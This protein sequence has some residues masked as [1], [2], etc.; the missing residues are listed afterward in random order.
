MFLERFARVDRLLRFARSDTPLGC[1]SC[2]CATQPSPAK[3]SRQPA[4]EA[5]ARA[6]A[7]AKTEWSRIPKN[8]DAWLLIGASPPDSFAKSSLGP[9]AMTLEDKF[10]IVR[11]EPLRLERERARLFAVV[12][13]ATPL[14][15]L[16]EV[17]S[18][19][20]EGLV[21]KEDIDFALVAPQHQ[22][23]V[24]RAALDRRFERDLQQ[25][26]N[27][28]YQGYIIPSTFDAAV[29]LLVA[30]SQY[31]TFDKFL[32]HLRESPP[33][34]KAYNDLKAKWNGLPM[35]D[36]RAAKRRFIEAALEGEPKTGLVTTGGHQNGARQA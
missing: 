7:T 8:S 3:L 19:A 23:E 36:Y 5:S 30:G 18:T 26:S 11:H 17:G 33:L 9:D 16:L 6:K 12:R 28:E 1:P 32:S 34:R 20:V 14:G 35:K 21:G 2:N 15:S 4:A 29:Q 27:C 22:F 13:D 25:I 31:D 24:V 10:R